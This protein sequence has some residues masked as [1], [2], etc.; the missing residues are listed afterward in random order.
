MIKGNVVV[1]AKNVIY[2]KFIFNYDLVLIRNFNIIK[3][4]FLKFSF[5]KYLKVYIIIKIFKI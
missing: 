2:F 1:A 4:D 5:K 3:Y